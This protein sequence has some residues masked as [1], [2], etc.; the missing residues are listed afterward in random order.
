MMDLVVVVDVVHLEGEA[1][2][3]L[4]RIQGSVLRQIAIRN[5]AEAG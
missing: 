2:F 3:L 4:A 5:R 1:E